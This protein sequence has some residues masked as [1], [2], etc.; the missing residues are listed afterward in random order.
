MQGARVLFVPGQMVNGV[1]GSF[2]TVFWNPVM[3]KQEGWM[4]LYCEK[5]SH[6]FDN[7][8]TDDHSD[9]QW[10]EIVMNAKAMI[11]DS[12]PGLRPLIWVIDSFK[13]NRRMGLLWE[14]KVGNGKLMVCSAD[15]LRLSQSNPVSRQLLYSILKYMDSEYFQPSF[16]VTGFQV[17][18]LIDQLK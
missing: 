15:L 2:T 8:P 18:L 6:V 17:K 4:G 5:E 16:P 12:Q 7:F 14:A 1:K 3:K 9:W 13:D 11:L 10:W